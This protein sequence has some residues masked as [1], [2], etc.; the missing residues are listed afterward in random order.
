MP[1]INIIQAHITAVP[2]TREVRVEA[3]HGP[4]P[5]HIHRKNVT[6]EIGMTITMKENIKDLLRK[7][8]KV[9]IMLIQ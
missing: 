2:A 6:D 7:I 3:I 4:D 8:I 9:H 1:V 5:D